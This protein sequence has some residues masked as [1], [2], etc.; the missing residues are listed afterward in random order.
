M[1]D[2]GAQIGDIIPVRCWEAVAK[3]LAFVQNR[4]TG[5][6]GE[7]PAGIGD[8]GAGIQEKPGEVTS[9]P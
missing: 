1:L 7:K 4:T 3:L 5:Q 6:A 9:K 2:R 8:P